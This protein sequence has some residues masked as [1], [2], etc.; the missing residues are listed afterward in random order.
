MSI[1][2]QLIAEGKENVAVKLHEAD[3]HPDEIAHRRL[4][5]VLCLR[6]EP[7]E[8]VDTISE[9]L[10][11]GVVTRMAQWF[12][13]NYLEPALAPTM[14]PPSGGAQEAAR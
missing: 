6:L 10:N 4:Y 1:V 14:T 7:Q 3:L 9:L 11:R 13:E 2:D 8:A 12:I 5:D